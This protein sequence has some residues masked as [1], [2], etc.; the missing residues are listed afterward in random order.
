VDELSLTI[1]IDFTFSRIENHLLPLARCKSWWI[2]WA[3]WTV[4]IATR[5]S[6]PYVFSYGV[7][8]SH[9]CSMPPT[10][11]WRSRN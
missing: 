8:W 11:H 1:N 2:D 5:T 10:Y 4:W 3:Q 7:V 6:G 9:L